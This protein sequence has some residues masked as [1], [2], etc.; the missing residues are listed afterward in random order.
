[1]IDYQPLLDSERVLVQQQDTLAEGRGLVG[2]DLV[3]VYKALGGG[4]QVEQTTNPPQ[5]PPVPV[6]PGEPVPSPQ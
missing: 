6:S 5:A 2:I 1:M 3:A 4:W